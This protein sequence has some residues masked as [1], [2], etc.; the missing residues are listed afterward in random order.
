ML[1]N[2]LWMKN[3]KRF[4]DQEIIF[5][6][7]ITG[8]I[9]NN[10][11][12]KSSIV[13]A[14]LFALYGLQGTGLDGDY[15]V[16][17]FAGPQDVCE[18]RLDFS[19]GGNDYTVLRRFKRRP[20]STL[21][22]ANLNMNQKL[23]ANSVQ[24][25]AS[26]I[27]R[28]VGMGAGDFRNTIYAGQKELLALLESRAGSRKDWF[29]QV[30]GIDYLK[31]DSMECLKELIDARE[32]TC[33]ELSGRLQELDPDGIRGRLLEL[34][35]AVAGAEE[36]AANARTAETGAREELESARREYERLLD[37]RER[38]R[39]LE[40]EEERLTADIERLRAECR[41]METEI[42]ARQRLQADLD[43]LQPI[44]ERYESL[45]AE[46]AALAEEKAH[47]ERLN[48]EAASL[49]EQIRD[50]A[51]RRSRLETDLAALAED[52]RTVAALEEDVRSARALRERIAAMKAL[53]PEYDALRE[54]IARLD[55]RFAHLEKRV[56]ENR[57]DIQELEEKE[58][59]LRALE[60]ETADY[61]SLL[62]RLEVYQEAQEH[63]RQVERSLHEAEAASAAARRIE[64]EISDLSRQI[65][66]LEGVEERIE[67]AERRKDDLTSRISA[68]AERREAIRREI[69]KVAGHR[70][71]I[72]AAGP[73]GTC[74]MCRQSLGDHY[75]D[76]LADLASTA[77]SLDRALADLEEEYALAVAGQKR[78]AAELKSLY[79]QRAALQRLKEQHALAAS[80]YEQSVDLMRRWQAEA[81]EHRAEIQA[82]GLEGGYD[83]AAH[84][85][86]RE[87]IRLLA[88]KRATA[89]TLRG[90]CSRLPALLE[91]RERLIADAA[92]HLARRDEAETRLYRLGFDPE[93]LKRLE[94]EAGA[95]EPV[96]RA[97]TEAQTRLA[98]RPA[99]KEDLNA[100]TARL[101]GLQERLRGV[102]GELAGLSF[103]PER[104]ERLNQE[105]SRA[106]SAHRR[107]LELRVR[108][109]EV[110]RLVE[111]LGSRRDLLAEREA[112]LLRVRAA[113]EELGF[114]GSMVKAAEERV[115][116]SEQR[117]TAARERMYAATLRISSLE[118][119]IEHETARLSRAE[120]LVRQRDALTEEIER[121]KLTRSL[122]RDYIDYL[123]QVVRG[124]IEEEAGRVLA[125]ITDGRYNTVMLDDDFSVLVHDMGEDYPAD[126]FSGGEQDDIA[127]ALRVALSRF[128][129]EVNQVH[130]STFLI[131]DEIFGS[132]DEER[133][134][135]LL[136]ALRT[137]EAYFPQII[138]ISHISEVQDEFSTA[139]LV[140]MG[141]DQISQVRV[142]D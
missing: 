97:Y 89:D 2:R 104:F 9:G 93:A 86:L 56:L 55:E 50:H 64:S 125:E 77:G 121:L 109:E 8:I 38:C 94:A 80:R 137:Q 72:L 71:E 6:D 45:K 40:R 90:E 7:G 76:L 133:R 27:Q 75:Q 74:P 51:D 65:A 33:R 15:I 100:I 46:V 61:E 68:F 39:E 25:V 131:F 127:I 106:E 60:E 62:A 26:E 58:R 28:I 17:S 70:E 81:D 48:L 134:A 110:P 10:G 105:Y 139:L 103:D 120:E 67:A 5:Q 115:A 66:E 124:R 54:E 82:L 69:Q 111:S 47:A 114:D 35:T 63:A 49:E 113:I 53:Q 12:G 41:D 129:A 107:A 18:V 36:E 43:E 24:K 126:R 42:A 20:S 102:R 138:L 34:R 13:S 37:L 135:N 73:E 92:D 101:D 79:A 87:R 108:L 96:S 14:I 112:E 32:G 11:A 44:V 22:E 4:R 122:I 95:L 130:D 84:E 23:L 123:L 141:P 136:R 88:G 59:H 3:F 140:E 16:S 132:Q 98:R 29:M 99:L 52:E 30:L 1:L 116:G 91:E 128:I 78:L 118:A 117:L 83:P 119:E 142:V 57:A 21:H 31:K 19:V 85:S